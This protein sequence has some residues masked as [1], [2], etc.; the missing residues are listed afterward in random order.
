[1]GLDPLSIGLLA[2][3]AVSQAV[4][5]N[6]SRK[7]AAAQKRSSQIE[8]NRQQGEAVRQRRQQARQ[9]RIRRAQVRQAAENTGTAGSSGAAGARSAI[10]S[11]QQS[12]GGYLS[13]QEVA[14]SAI[15]R[16]N[17]RA[18]DSAFR[19]TIAQQ[20]SGLALQGATVFGGPST[21]SGTTSTATP[22]SDIGSIGTDLFK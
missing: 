19:S 16:S 5:F 7:S 17:Q 3:S 9:A 11:F 13:G 14:A 4:S 10:T 18:A 15:S 20:I 22:T 8:S 21:T 2:F 12:A 1:M 6:E